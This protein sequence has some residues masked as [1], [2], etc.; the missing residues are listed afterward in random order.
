MRARGAGHR[1]SDVTDPLP[2][3]VVATSSNRRDHHGVDTA[4]GPGRAGVTGLLERTRELSRLHECSTETA[5]LRRGSV[6]LVSGE[7]G[8]GKTALLRQFR[9]SLPR[10][11]SVL[12]G[13][14]D[15][16]FTPRPLGPL[17][18]PAA[19]IG[20]ELAILVE[21]D[22]LPHEVAGALLSELRGR[23]PSVLVLE[24]LHF[25]DEATLDVVRLM[26]RRIES[27][28]SLL[29]LSFR[30]D[31]L[32]ADHPLQLV[33]GE[34]PGQSVAARLE[35]SGLSRSAVR[36]MAEHS[37][38]DADALYDRTAGNPFYVTETLAARAEVVPA[39][40]R[41]AV[42]ARVARLSLAARDV[43]DAVAV[44]PQRAEIWLL[45][46]MTDRGLDAL[47]E[48]LHSGVL[49]AEADGV[50]FRHELAR[51]TVENALAPD[52]AVSLHRR[53]LAA[54]SR[55]ELGA[56]DLARL[57][58]HAEAAGEGPAVL[59]YAPAAGE[60]AASLGAP[61]EAQDQ[62]LR[63]LRFAGNLPSE[64]RA[65]LIER[66][67]DHAYLGAQRDEA[68]DAMTEVIT[69]Y[70]RAGDHIRH[71]D[72]LLRRAR[73]LACIG[74]FPEA[75]DA[76]RESVRVLELA[77]PGPELARAYSMLAGV[78][79]DLDPE[80][81]IACGERG[82]ELA[83]R[84]GATGPL[85][86]ALNNVGMIRMVCGDQSGRAQLER[87]LVLAIHNGLGTDAGRAF[88][89]L[90]SCLGH[91]GRWTEAMDQIEPGIE[92]CREHGLEAWLKSLLGI[93]AE[94]ELALGDWDAAAE[95]AVAILAAPRDQILAPRLEALTVLAL[96]RARRG[97][98]EHRPLLDEA[99]ELVRDSGQLDVLALVAAARAEAAWLEGR[100]A[101]IAD[102]TAETLAVAEQSGAGGYAGELA[103]W[104]RRGGL[105]V[106]VP[107]G[108]LEHHR[109]LLTGDWAEAA[110]VLRERGCAYEAALA[111]AD[112]GEPG[113]LR[114]A[115]DQLQRM[116]A[117]SAATIVARRLRELGERAV[118]RGPR[119]P[120]R[121][122]AAGLTRRELEVL[123]LLAEGL[124]NAEI[125]DR[126]IV[127]TKTVDH[128]VSSIL[129]KLGVGTRGQAAAAAAR[130][131]LTQHTDSD[132]AGA[133]R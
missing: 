78:L 110:R 122:N 92:Y 66:Y 96:V 79:V 38:L 63:A 24:D 67:A 39:T 55:P 6:V 132:I 104:R 93:R 116:G 7:A 59:R 114:D 86:H 103:V 120:T 131:G 42:L 72:A 53:A 31:C 58:H 124:R 56:P 119:A 14:C 51:L 28:A 74:R 33:L 43:L 88:I 65:P 75:G 60:H 101:L 130:L 69:T 13:T 48:C 123:P 111:L 108:A 9:A 46:Y 84:L 17:L 11:F 106:E 35:L 98:P 121:A 80:A 77:P 105:V 113:A 115:L 133:A 95:T 100:P 70:R 10:R 127:S 107:S 19:E 20:G 90:T 57:A 129:H 45:E 54:L 118:P 102:E 109:L 41:A 30:D 128:H 40:V 12:W 29:A 4:T 49:R 89:N 81:A 85:V 99:R 27:V 64:E 37:V 97:D 32:H 3:A 15:P 82:I 61:R 94:A 71:G 36:A 34:L 91:E 62:Y 1:L 16:L 125:A 8:I 126:L 2:D 21:G 112:S 25:A 23:A 44:V 5:E 83:E 87:S 73:L 76:I 68:A 26:V 50:V 47:D 117:R 22:A 52:R 18:E